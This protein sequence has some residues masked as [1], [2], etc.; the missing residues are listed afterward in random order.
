MV[1]NLLGNGSRW[2]LTKGLNCGSICK[3]ALKRYL[4]FNAILLRL[5]IG[6]SMTINV[7][8][9][10][11]H[12]DKLLVHQEWFK[13]EVCVFEVLVHNILVGVMSGLSGIVFYFGGLG[14]TGV[15]GAVCWVE[16][17]TGGG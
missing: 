2:K 15:L 7:S 3:H 11:I 14:E 6:D 9:I 5:P 1:D 13:Y 8:H 4:D 12:I 10:T 16:A 17:G